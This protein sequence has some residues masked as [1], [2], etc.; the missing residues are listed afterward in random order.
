MTPKRA[1]KVRETAIRTAPTVERSEAT[2]RGVVGNRTASVLVDEA[3]AGTADPGTR[4][5]HFELL[6]AAFGAR[7]DLTTITAHIGNRAAAAAHALGAEA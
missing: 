6:Q 7:H 5:P 3:R 4:L 1:P 2:S